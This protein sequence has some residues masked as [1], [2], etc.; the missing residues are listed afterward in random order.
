MCSHPRAQSSQGPEWRE[1]WPCALTQSLLGVPVWAQQGLPSR[2]LGWG[3]S[4][5]GQDSRARAPLQGKWLSWGPWEGGL[6]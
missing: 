5:C 4:A 2:G 6:H 1:R 3:K